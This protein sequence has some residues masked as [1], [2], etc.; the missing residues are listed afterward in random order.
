MQYTGHTPT[1]IRALMHSSVITKVTVLFL[2]SLSGTNSPRS[3]YRLLLPKNLSHLA[4]LAPFAHNAAC[5][6]TLVISIMGLAFRS[7]PMFDE[8][9]REA[10]EVD[11]LMVH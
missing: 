3:F 4:P 2:L 9:E 11:P 6:A 1:H 5:A 10:A 8:T 7:I